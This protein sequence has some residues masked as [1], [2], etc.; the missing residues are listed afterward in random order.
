MRDL[1][2]W[3]LFSFVIGGFLWNTY[4]WWKSEFSM[5]LVD[6]AG[7]IGPLFYWVGSVILLFAYLTVCMIL[8]VKKEA[9]ENTA[10][11]FEFKQVY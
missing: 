2:G 9:D 6:N 5:E 3:G 11:K 1:P 10:K 4:S 8:W 7:N